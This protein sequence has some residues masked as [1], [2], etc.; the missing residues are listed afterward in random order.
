M[1]GERVVIDTALCPTNATSVSLFGT[2]AKKNNRL[3]TLFGEQ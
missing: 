2:R 1:L 3:S